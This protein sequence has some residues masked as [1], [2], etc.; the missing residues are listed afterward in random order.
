MSALCMAS[1]LGGECNVCVIV[2]RDDLSAL[3]CKFP[4]TALSTSCYV[5][6]HWLHIRPY[7]CKGIDIP[8]EVAGKSAP[9]Y[10]SYQSN[11][12]HIGVGKLGKYG[13][14]NLPC[15]KPVLTYH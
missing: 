7:T 10:L 3:A 12:P 6:T 13:F 4:S 1:R 11:L 2:E 15:C 14:A 8:G 9:T 5:Y